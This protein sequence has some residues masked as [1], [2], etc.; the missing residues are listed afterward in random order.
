M[1]ASRPNREEGHRELQQLESVLD[2]RFDN[3][4]LLRRAM[5]HRSYANERPEVETD[6][7]RLEFLGDAVLGLVV[8]EALFRE[9]E[10]APEGVLSSRL[11]E[12]VCEPAL[13]ERAGSLEL[14]A[15]LHLGRGEELTGGRKKEALLADAYEAL[16]GALYLDG[17]YAVVRRIILDHFAEAIEAMEAKQAIGEAGSPGDYKSLLQREVQRH[18]PMRPAYRIADTSGPPHDRRF[19]AEVLVEGQVVGRGG[20]RSKKEAEQNAAAEAVADLESPDGQLA[21]ILEIAAESE[22]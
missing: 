8:A 9:D 17:G 5:I 10:K 20:G 4:E 3:R 2:Y 22:D 1:S 14:G 12:L 13:V 16:L 6:N 7:Q 18:R 19:V 15:Y 11:S 21:A